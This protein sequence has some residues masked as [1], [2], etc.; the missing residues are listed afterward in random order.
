[1]ATNIPGS[2]LSST[3]FTKY[4]VNYNEGSILIG[5][6]EPCVANACCSWTDE[7]PIKDIRFVGLSA[8]DRHIGYRNIQVLPCLPFHTSITMQSNGSYPCT[9]SGTTAIHTTGGDAH[10]SLPCHHHP[11]H[12]SPSPYPLPTSSPLL[13]HSLT[14]DSRTV[15]INTNNTMA[16]YV[17]C[18][19]AEGTH[20]SAAFRS[21]TIV[22]GAATVPSLIELSCQALLRMMHVEERWACPVLTA[23]DTLSPV[24]DDLR[25]QAIDT[26][27]LQFSNILSEDVAGFRG[28]SATSLR[29]VFKHQSLVCHEKLLFD[30]LLLWAGYCD[31]NSSNSR[32]G[33]QYFTDE[34]IV[35]PD[36]R[37][38]PFSTPSSSLI[39][40]PS[41]SLHPEIDKN[42]MDH[43]HHDSAGITL[44]IPAPAYTHYDNAAL[45]SINA[46]LHRTLHAD[47]EPLLPHIR[48]PLMS[49]QELH[50]ISQH[51]VYNHS[52]VLQNLVDEALDIINN[53]EHC[54]G[55]APSVRA[56]RLLRGLTPLEAEASTRLQRRY[57]P[58]CTQLI[59]MYDGDQNGVC[60]YLGTRY[61]TQQWVNP[62]VAGYV[63]VKASSP[64][65]RGTDPRGLLSGAFLRNNFAGPKI[66]TSSGNVSSWWSID[67]GQGHA[68]HCDYY[69]LRHDASSNYLRSWALQ[70]SND[71]AVWTD[72]RRHED[73]K[74]LKLPG[75]YASWPVSGGTGMRGGFRYFRVMMVAPNSEAPN[76]YHV[77][78]S[79]VELYGNFYNSSR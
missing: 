48:F 46:V 52:S 2:R 42:C 32:S 29:D 75:Q 35:L 79:Y 47:I 1:M 18:G 13:C 14:M 61:G 68:L 34:D 50:E 44:N 37:S 67:L 7:R 58:G 12:L 70:G 71:G 76:P 55:I 26:I 43:G 33:E 54:T 73:E 74:T 28:L 39:S 57:P 3:C 20:I 65:S 23:T 49:L 72:L 66:D 22:P 15:S 21:T 27:A 10:S 9:T 56:H 60:W 41:L 8:W 30:A 24:V 40:P 78:L 19:H 5:C 16:K 59:Y 69:T 4:W 25:T 6:G 77:C 17:T 62:V 53:A 64:V 63:D 36:D 31:N 51:P 45:Q 11:M 38:I